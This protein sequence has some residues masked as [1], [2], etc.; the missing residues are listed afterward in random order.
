M[1]ILALGISL[2][3]YMDG[4]IGA[5]PGCLYVSSSD[6]SA[7]TMANTRTGPAFQCASILLPDRCRTGSR[8]SLPVAR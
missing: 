2:F 6:E 4:L 3:Q 8:V 1:L 7:G 5:P